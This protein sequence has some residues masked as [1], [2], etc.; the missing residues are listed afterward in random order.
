MLQDSKWRPMLVS[1]DMQR[2]PPST[3]SFI[4]EQL[5]V[6]WSISLGRRRHRRQSLVQTASPRPA[7]SGRYRWW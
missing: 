1:A 5:G 2:P 7:Q 4:G 6:A 3:S